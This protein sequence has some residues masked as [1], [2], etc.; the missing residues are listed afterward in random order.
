MNDNGSIEVN[1]RRVPYYGSDSS[2]KKANSTTTSNAEGKQPFKK[3]LDDESNKGQEQDDGQTKVSSDDR[4]AGDPVA[5]NDR[6]LGG[7]PKKLAS[8]FD[9]SN[10]Q[11]QTRKVA[12]QPVG[13]QQ[14]VKVSAHA[15]EEVEVNQASLVAVAE[16]K[17]SQKGAVA[18]EVPKNNQPIP[19]DRSQLIATAEG[20]LQAKPAILGSTVEAKVAPQDGFVKAQGQA[21]VQPQVSAQP[22]VNVQPQ[23]QP[24]ANAQSQVNVQP[25]LQPQINAKAQLNAPPTAAPIQLGAGQYLPTDAN[26]IPQ[27]VKNNAPL[28]DITL[29]V[30]GEAGATQAQLASSV[31]TPPLTQEHI[32]T[33]V[34]QAAVKSEVLPKPV[35]TPDENPI[36]KPHDPFSFV[37]KES[38]NVKESSVGFQANFTREPI[39]MASV[40]QNIIPQVAP[41]LDV[42]A[43]VAQAPMPQPTVRANLQELINQMVSQIKE[44]TQNGKTE[45]SIVL[46][47]PPIFEGA[48]LTI[49][50]FDTANDQFN[51]A[52][53]NLRAPAQHLLDLQVHRSQLLDN[54]KNQFGLNVHIFTTSTTTENRT[55]FAN[56]DLREKERDQGQPDDD[57]QKQRRQR[58]S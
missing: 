3:V 23:L 16:G 26:G 50:A 37:S 30:K 54:L 17:T 5:L 46:K 58:Q 57:Q 21:N 9:L 53:E 27:P 55:T 24:Q 6:S 28:S 43:S 1:S 38:R 47:H 33:A 51:I 29:N 56:A 34:P 42:A 4:E 13:V 48:K 41:T 45:T 10:A 31:K 7:K 44:L 25:Q 15:S 35:G 32:T 18:V 11:T 39:D 12:E 20:E 8:P 52:F 2:T 40:N 14:D 36:G 49:T 22:Q 19:Q